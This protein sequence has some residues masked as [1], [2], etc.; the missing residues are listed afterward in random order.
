MHDVPIVVAIQRIV[1][2]A[3][4]RPK[5]S[6]RQTRARAHDAVC[7]IEGLSQREGPDWRR[8]VAFAFVN[9]AAGPAH[10]TP[11]TEV[12]VRDRS[13]RHAR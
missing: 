13:R 2:P 12:S 3:I 4:I 10:R 8:A 6:Q 9:A 11:E 5:R 7:P 1:A